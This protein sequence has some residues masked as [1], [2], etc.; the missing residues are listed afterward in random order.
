MQGEPPK[1]YEQEAT[2]GTKGIATNGVFEATHVGSAPQGLPLVGVA[3]RGPDRGRHTRG[4]DG[5]RGPVVWPG[6]TPVVTL[7]RPD[8]P[9]PTYSLMLG[10]FSGWPAASFYHNSP[11]DRSC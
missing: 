11:E 4:L 7:E 8:V 10:S 3:V 9:I 6:P 1:A 2:N 5:G